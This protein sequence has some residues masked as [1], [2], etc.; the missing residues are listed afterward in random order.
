M[1]DRTKAPRIKP[2]GILTMP[3][4]NIEQ[5]SNG[6]TVHHIAA[7]SDPVC[8]IAV[9]IDGGNAEA[10]SIPLAT[11]AMSLLPDG[12]I[13][14][15]EDEIADILDFNGARITPRSSDHHSSL[16]LS[17]LNNTA[18]EVVPLMVECLQ[19]PLY[20]ADKIEVL[21]LRLRSAY[22]TN[23]QNVSWLAE[24]AFNNALFGGEHPLVGINTLEKIDSF[25]RDE[26]IAWHR[27]LINPASMHVF[28]S[29]PQ[30]DLSVVDIIRQSFGA[31]VP[32]GNGVEQIYRPIGESGISRRIDVAKEDA[33][34][35]AIFTGFPTIDRSHPDYIALRL[36][37]MG[38][39][40][41]FGSRLMANIREDKGLTYG[42]SA[43]LY[44]TPEGAYV[45]ISAEFDPM[46]TDA[47]ITEIDSEIRRMISDPPSGP[48]LDRLKL[49]AS[50][51]LAESLES[52]AAIG[53]YY[54]TGHVLN[55]APDYFEQQMKEIEA[56][57]PEKISHVIGSYYS[58]DR[59]L[60]VVA[61]AV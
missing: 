36:A 9:V 13:A 37:V 40:G 14:R 34:Q 23:M 53:S 50:T 61:G 52:A 29:G 25:T 12:S 16:M 41:Y 33:V 17:F 31:I 4:Q 55:L 22:L 15:T 43:G 32:I 46:F 51:S 21:R 10:R 59:Q 57:S 7:G 2:F 48:E 42:I 19:A 26:L 49:Y 1:L 47:V 6:V 45:G 30:G 39:G 3:P 20:D 56:L 18:T 60:T 5:L 27:R 35:N 11:A 8:Q 28:V 44:G 54:R 24:E 38:L 58:P